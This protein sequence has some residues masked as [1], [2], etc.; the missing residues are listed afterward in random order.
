MIEVIYVA[1]AY[2][3]RNRSYRARAYVGEPRV[4]LHSRVVAMGDTRDEAENEAVEHIRK[5]YAAD[6]LADRSP[7]R[8]ERVG[9]VAASLLDAYAF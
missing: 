1:Y 8:V 5:I 3:R 6:G 7:S 9:R 2:D 4:P